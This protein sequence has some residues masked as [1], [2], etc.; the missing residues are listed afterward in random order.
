MMYVCLFKTF[1]WLLCETTHVWIDCVC[2][3]SLSLCTQNGDDDDA[4][5]SVDTSEAAVKA[6]KDDL[7]GLVS[8]LTLDDS[9]KSPAERVN[10]FFTFVEVSGLE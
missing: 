2:V 9:E 1:V 10:I 7:T 3:C 5:W 4:N 8:T 6:R